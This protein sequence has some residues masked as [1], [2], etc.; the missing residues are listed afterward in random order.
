VARLSF[1]IVI[2]DLNIAQ[3]KL[4]RPVAVSESSNLLLQGVL[5]AVGFRLGLLVFGLGAS[6]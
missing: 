5:R 4:Q 1:E 6:Q 3:F 2:R